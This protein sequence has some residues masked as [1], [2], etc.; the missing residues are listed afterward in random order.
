MTVV[1]DWVIH[2]CRDS[3]IFFVDGV[4]QDDNTTQK[5]LAARDSTSSDELKI[6][7]KDELYPI[8]QMVAY[9][10]NTPSETLALLATDEDSWVRDGVATNPNTPLKTLAILATDEDWHVRYVAAHN[11]SAT[12]FVQRVYLMTEAKYKNAQKEPK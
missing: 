1:F 9:N 5:F 7:A 11:P 4:K 3:P 10:R 12:D 6:L 2:H 8:R